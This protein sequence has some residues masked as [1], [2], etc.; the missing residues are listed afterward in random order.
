[1][2]ISIPITDDLKQQTRTANSR[3]SINRIPIQIHQKEFYWL[4]VK[5]KEAGTF[6]LRLDTLPNQYKMQ[7]RGYAVNGFVFG[8]FTEAGV[9]NSIPLD[10]TKDT[11]AGRKY[12]V[13]KI[14]RYFADQ[15]KTTGFDFVGSIQVWTDENHSAPM[16]TVSREKFNLCVQYHPVQKQYYLLISYQGTSFISNRNLKTLSAQ[17]D[18]DM[19]WVGRVIY[20]LRSWNYSKLVEATN[21]ELEEVFPI[22]N[23]NLYKQLVIRPLSAK[24][25]DPHYRN[26]QMIRG[27]YENYLCQKPFLEVVDVQAGWEMI[28]SVQ[29]LNDPDNRVEFG[30]GYITDDVMNG[31]KYASPYKL[32]PA[33]QIRLFFIYYKGSQDLYDRLLEGMKKDFHFGK[34][35][36][37]SLYYDLSLNIVFDDPENALE[38]ITRGIYTL[39]LDPEQKYL[40]VYLS[41]FDRF[42]PDGSKI[43]VVPGVKEALLRRSVMSQVIDAQK[44]D[45]SAKSFRYWLPNIA[46]A[47]MSKFG[48]IPWIRSGNDRNDLVLG[49]GVYKSNKN[50]RKFIGTSV[51]FRNDGS[52]ESFDAFP[53]MEAFQLSST[54]ERALINYQKQYPDVNRIVLHYYKDISSTELDPI[55]NMLERI[56]VKIPLYVLRISKTSESTYMVAD[57]TSPSLLPVNGTYHPLGRDEYLLYLNDRQTEDSSLKT[58]PLALRIGIRCSVGAADES[59]IQDLLGQL[60]DYCFMSWRSVRRGH[61]PAT[62]LYPRLLAAY[63]AYFSSGQLPEAGKTS[64]W[65]L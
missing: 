56:K 11:F 37:T 57:A 39:T 25:K 15:K 55:E 35:A 43:A 9:E 23:L 22:M 14:H 50:F 59:L 6:R 47:S 45:G 10:M 48:G 54:L 46:I 40:A 60:Y 34:N 3:Y 16:D 19:K 30:G 52:F 49:F 53:S 2:N 27:F 38:T 44:F 31:F 51:C 29:R 18:F 13:E 7:Y 17:G 33:H 21:P 62:V 26:W 36:G 1:M 41:P 32:M 4:P 8:R 64:M 28:P 12:L 42:H 65:V 61:V 58:A 5:S 20:R 63:V 24:R